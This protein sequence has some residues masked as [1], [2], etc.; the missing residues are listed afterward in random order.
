MGQKIQQIYQNNHCFLTAL[1][2]NVFNSNKLFSKS[3]NKDRIR[4]I[5]LCVFFYQNALF[6]SQPVLNQLV[7]GIIHFFTSSLTGL[8]QELH[9]SFFSESTAGTKKPWL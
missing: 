5:F 9:E 2:Q 4:E 7:Q 6:F 8:S 3:L 1:L